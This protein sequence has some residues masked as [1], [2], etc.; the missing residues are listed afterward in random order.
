MNNREWV[1]IPRCDGMYQVNEFGD[2]RS[3]KYRHTDKPTILKPRLIRGYLAVDLYHKDKRF[4][5]SNHQAVAMAFLGHTLD[6]PR[7]T[8]NH[9]DFN[10]LNN[11]KSNLEIISLRE[12]SS[13]KSDRGNRLIGTHKQKNGKFASMIMHN[14]KRYILGYFDIESHASDAYLKAL[15][16]INNGI[17][18][19][20]YKP[21]QTSEYKGVHYDKG[22]NR[23]LC[24]LYL[25]GE[26]IYLGRFKTENLAINAIN[27]ARGEIYLF[28]E[29]LSKPKSRIN[30]RKGVTF[31]KDLNK[32]GVRCGGLFIGNYKTEE[33]GISISE[34]YEM[35]INGGMT[36]KDFKLSLKKP[37][38]QKVI[39]NKSSNV[40]GITYKSTK[41]IWESYHYEQGKKLYVGSFKSE[42]DAINA[43]NKFKI[44]Q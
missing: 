4:T 10:K 12:N 3:L 43:L 15:D 29:V 39:R 13:Y 30:K 26:K 17:E 22:I 44:N 9:K 11:H 28:G 16:D 5:I 19:S 23:W 31:S 7:I 1:D 37:K 25:N 2:I 21:Q 36:I 20:E 34:R 27:I 35:A 42:V 40:K 32:W 33:E 41:D 24:N 18:I 8:V 6:N 38:P 14:G